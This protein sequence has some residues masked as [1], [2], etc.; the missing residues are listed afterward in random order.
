MNIQFLELAKNTH[1][2]KAAGGKSKL[3]LLLLKKKKNRNA[4]SF[5]L[6]IK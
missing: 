4:I 6:L 3:L 1:T 2:Y 5:W